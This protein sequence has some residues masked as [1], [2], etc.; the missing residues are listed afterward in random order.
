MVIIV[1]INLEDDLAKLVKGDEAV[2][3]LKKD[4]LEVAKEDIA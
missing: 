2:E 4:V 1:P 3:W